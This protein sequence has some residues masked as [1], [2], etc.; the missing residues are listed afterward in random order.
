ML[1]LGKAHI[2]EVQSSLWDEANIEAC[3]KAGITLL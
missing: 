3:R 2:G 1:M